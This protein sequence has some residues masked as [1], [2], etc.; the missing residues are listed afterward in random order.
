MR[1]MKNITTNI[2]ILLFLN[3][4]VAFS[5]IREGETLNAISAVVGKQI[6]T[7]A[8]VEAEVMTFKQIDPTNKMSD[9]EMFEKVLENLINQNLIS[10]S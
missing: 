10:F 6:I 3:S 9:D 2:I 8:E 1:Y 7:K 4:I 5:Q